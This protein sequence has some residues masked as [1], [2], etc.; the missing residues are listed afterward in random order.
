M[1]ETLEPSCLHGI[2]V[3]KRRPGAGR[4]PAGEVPL[5]R[6]VQGLKGLGKD[7]VKTAYGVRI[8]LCGRCSRANVWCRGGR[9]M[10]PR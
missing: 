5:A 9:A 7:E 4:E 10:I 1:E 6:C 2:G 8:G 3:L